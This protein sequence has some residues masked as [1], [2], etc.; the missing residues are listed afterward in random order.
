MESRLQ[1]LETALSRLDLKTAGRAAH[2][3]VGA[4]A[5]LGASRMEAIAVKM[6]EAAGRQDAAALRE[7]LPTLRA[8]YKAA[9]EALRALLT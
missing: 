5:N 3:V 6:E 2:T 4:S 8:R 9:E 1:E 7:Q